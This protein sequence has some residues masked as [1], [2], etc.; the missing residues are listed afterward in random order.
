MWIILQ[1]LCLEFSLC[2]LDFLIF[3]NDFTMIS[4]IIASPAI[5]LSVKIRFKIRLDELVVTNRSVGKLG[6]RLARSLKAILLLV[7]NRTTILA[8]T[9]AILRR[10][11]SDVNSFAIPLIDSGILI[12]VFVLWSLMLQCRSTRTIVPRSCRDVLWDVGIDVSS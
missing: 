7:R 9:F 10:D 5:S 12:L 11:F 6:S 1:L 8:S 3:L 4:W 2:F